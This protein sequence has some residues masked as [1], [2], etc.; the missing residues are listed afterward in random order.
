MIWYFYLGIALIAGG[1]LNAFFGSPRLA[2][3]TTPACWWGYILVLDAVIG[4]VRGKSL[5]RNNFP[6]FL[7]Q[8]V[9]SL[10][11]WCVFE[12]N[13]LH[14]RNWKYVDLPPHPIE[15]ILGMALSFATILPG[16]FF[17][18]EVIDVSG[19]FKKI[20][21]PP[22]QVSSRLSYILIFLGIF[23]LVLPMMLPGRQAA[24]LFI[25]IWLGWI[26]F[27]DPINYYS[28][29]QSVL[30]DLSRGEGNR[31]AALFA[32]GLIC[33]FL[34]EFWNFRAGSKW[35]YTAPFTSGI[36]IFE[37]PVTGFLGFLPFAL[38][39]FA[40]YHTAR[41]VIGRRIPGAKSLGYAIFD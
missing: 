39:F 13:N 10:L 5:I 37:M 14:L 31:I 6:L 30:G 11:F 24:Y 26:F 8:L 28:G 32:S 41:L 40:A 16:L 4:K 21:L 17:T 1:M 22:L 12:V 38:E 20:K 19:V 35:V 15:S 2:D 33:G 36:K 29:T 18:A 3:W 25:L 7:Y 27:L 23:C 34:W 9:F